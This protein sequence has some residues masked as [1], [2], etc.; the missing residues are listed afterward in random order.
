MIVCPKITHICAVALVHKVQTGSAKKRP[1]IRRM[2]L[3]IESLKDFGAW[4]T[5]ISDGSLRNLGGKRLPTYT[6]WA[7]VM[8]SRKNFNDLGYN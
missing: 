1:P 8:G 7:K 3:M 4:T 2:L 6:V 5:I